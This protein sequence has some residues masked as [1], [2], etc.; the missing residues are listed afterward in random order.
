MAVRH[1]GDAALT[2]PVLRQRN[3]APRGHRQRDHLQVTAVGS[4]L[5]GRLRTRVALVDEG[6]LHRVVSYLLHAVGQRRHLY[7]VVF[8]G[9]R[10]YNRQQ[11]PQRSHGQV[12]RRA[13]PPAV[14]IVASVSPRVLVSIAVFD[15]PRSRHE[16]WVRGR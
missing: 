5:G 8:V 10:D 7:P 12:H 3:N 2:H 13:F 16:A 11:L 9:E 14:P 4:R 6:H 1:P 15:C